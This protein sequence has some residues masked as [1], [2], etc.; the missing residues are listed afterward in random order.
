MSRGGGDPATNWALFGAGFVLG[1]SV[2][3]AEQLPGQCVGNSASTLQNG[4]LTYTA[5][6]KY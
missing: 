1:A 5:W 6:N 3:Y 4:Y 2:D